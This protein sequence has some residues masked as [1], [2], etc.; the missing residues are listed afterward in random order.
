MKGQP[1]ESDTCD[2]MPDRAPG[3]NTQMGLG[4][5]DGLQSVSTLVARQTAGADLRPALGRRDARAAHRQPQFA[6]AY[7]EQGEAKRDDEIDQAKQQQPCHQLLAVE[8][9]E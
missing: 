2:A 7:R 4:E 8:L 6:G 5:A 3:E 9:A 1:P